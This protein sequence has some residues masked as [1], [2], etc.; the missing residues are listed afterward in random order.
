MRHS[1]SSS[2]S[3]AGTDI[4]VPRTR[5]LAQKVSEAFGETAEFFGIYPP[6]P[7]C[8]ACVSAPMT[9]ESPEH[10]SFWATTAAHTG[11]PS[12]PWW[13][14]DRAPDNWR[15]APRGNAW[16]GCWFR[17]GHWTGRGFYFYDNYCSSTYTSYVCS[18][19]AWDA[20]PPPPP[21]APPAPPAPPPLYVPFKT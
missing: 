14:N 18:S 6:E 21:S 12:T 5:E 17:A 8:G 13:V 15:S 16:P 7:G 9:S 20:A 3:A 4:W 1:L 19:N 11:A 10:A 2:Q